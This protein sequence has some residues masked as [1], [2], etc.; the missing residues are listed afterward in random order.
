MN[1]G[2]EMAR[3]Q[4]T[5]PVPQY[6]A[7]ETE[8]KKV[9]PTKRRPF[10]AT[11]SVGF[12]WIK[13]PG[14]ISLHGLQKEAPSARCKQLSEFLKLFII[15]HQQTAAPEK[16]ICV[17]KSHH[18]LHRAVLSNCRLVFEKTHLSALF[19]LPAAVA[20]WPLYSHKTPA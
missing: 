13:A 10:A 19:S 4:Q 11:N 5:H 15:V 8:T 18:M 1:N 9:T 3:R 12:A 16:K 6:T 7:M 2:L 17:S 14:I 20:C